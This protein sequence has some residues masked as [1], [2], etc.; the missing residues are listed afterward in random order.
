MNESRPTTRVKENWKKHLLQS[1]I[2]LEYQVARILADEGMSVDADFSFVRQDGANQKEF[3]V[4][5]KAGWYGGSRSGSANFDLQLLVECKYRAPHKS[6]LFLPDPNSI[7]PSYT[8]GGTVSGFDLFVPY[9]LPYDAFVEVE[10]GVEIVYKAVETS[11]E[12]AVEKDIRHG[13][14]QLRYAAPALLRQMFD[15]QLSS[16]PSEVIPIYLAKILVTNAPIRVLHSQCDIARIEAAS[17]LD[18]LSENINT[19]IMFSDYGPDFEDH[20]RRLFSNNIQRRIEGA[21]I[22]RDHLS[23][24]G[25]SMSKFCDPVQFL[26]RLSSGSRYECRSV[27]TQ[28]FVTTLGGLTNLIGK[29][30]TGCRSSYKKRTKTDPIS[31]KIRKSSKEFRETQPS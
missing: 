30:K 6:I 28:F 24:Q 10:H 16:H 3:S 8:L 20:F 26:E 1:G 23:R 25:K 13:I 11:S 7:Y 19:V 9:F 17:S 31:R 4:D 27:S 22:L 2:P 12:G 29:I 15:Y 18:E 14:Q 5:I 21:S